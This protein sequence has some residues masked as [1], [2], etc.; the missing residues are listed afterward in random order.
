MK[1]SSMWVWASMPPGNT[2]WPEAS[3]TSLSAGTTRSGPIAT[4]RPPSQ[5]TSATYWSRAVTMV[6][7]R[8]TTPGMG[9][10]FRSGCDRGGYGRTSSA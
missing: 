10:S 1:G 5:K 9:L 2:Y 8:M 4:I 7:L 6:P 3:M